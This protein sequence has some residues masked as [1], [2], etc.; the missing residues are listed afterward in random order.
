MPILINFKICDNSPDCNGIR[1]CKFGALVFNE[2]KQT[3]EI[4]NEKCVSCGAC[5]NACEVFAIKLAKTK[6]EYDKMQKEIDDDPRTIKDLIAERYGGTPLQGEE[7]V[8]DK[9]HFD[10]RV[11]KSKLKPRIVEFNTEDTIECLIKSIP[12]REIIEKYHKDAT[13]AKFMITKDDFK[14]FNIKSTP[15]LRFYYKG[16]LIKSIDKYYT[17]EEKQELFAE[18]PKIPQ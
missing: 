5:V 8:W 15:C 12:V 2:Q 13:Y 6:A 9:S 1:A 14:T 16:Q 17:N 10:L 3:L 11:L 4:D 7:W 18:I